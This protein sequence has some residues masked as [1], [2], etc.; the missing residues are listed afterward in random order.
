M[1][2]TVAYSLAESALSKS[3]GRLRRNGVWGVRRSGRPRR[4]WCCFRYHAR[5]QWAPL[6]HARVTSPSGR[7]YLTYATTLNRCVNRSL[8]R[9]IRRDNR[10]ILIPTKVMNEGCLR[11][12]RARIFLIIVCERRL[13]VRAKADRDDSSSR[14]HELRATIY[15]IKRAM[16]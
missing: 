14:G 13:V 4:G 15:E 16:V 2:N 10:L 6:I 3:S 8:K 7:L 12:T 5:K 1:T 9:R 11:S